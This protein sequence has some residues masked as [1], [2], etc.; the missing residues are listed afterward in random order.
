VRLTATSFSTN[1]S[2]DSLPLSGLAMI[3]IPA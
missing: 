1:S 2:A 3:G